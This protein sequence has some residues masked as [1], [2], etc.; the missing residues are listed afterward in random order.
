M[1]AICKWLFAVYEYHEKSQIVRPK[2][3]KLAQEEANLAIA[4]DK[5]EKSR[6]ELRIIKEKLAMLNENS[7]KQMDVKNELEMQAMRTK[8][9][10]N[11]AETLIN[12]LSG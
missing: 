9:K 12:S 11:T 2:R 3:I 4:M 6:E 8:K 5:L 7:Q 10:I 1:Q